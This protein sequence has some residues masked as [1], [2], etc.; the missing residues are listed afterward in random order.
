MQHNAWIRIHQSPTCDKSHWS[1]V[2]NQCA[3][4]EK[5]QPVSGLKGA[6][7]GLTSL[8]NMHTLVWARRNLHI[9]IILKAIRKRF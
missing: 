5:R 7:P 9:R 3:V 6:G 1:Y 2:N 8:P 4:Y